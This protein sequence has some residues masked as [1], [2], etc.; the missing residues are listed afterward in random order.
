MRAR[1]LGGVCVAGWL[2]WQCTN[3]R[4]DGGERWPRC[5]ASVNGLLAGGA[6]ASNWRAGTPARRA[7]AAPARARCALIP[8]TL[9]A[10]FSD[11]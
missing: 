10:L 3:R 7:H 6:T 2:D 8:R 5:K 9:T 4:I 11:T 1:A